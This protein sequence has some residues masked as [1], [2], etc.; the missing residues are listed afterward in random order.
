MNIF[1]SCCTRKKSPIYLLEDEE[2]EETG[3]K[4]WFS[5]CLRPKSTYEEGLIRLPVGRRT[6]DD[7]LDP[8]SPISIETLLADQEE[9]LDH[10]LTHSSLE[11]TF[12]RKYSL[13][14]TAI[15]E[16]EDAQFLSEHRISAILVD[17]PKLGG[18]NVF[19]SENI[20]PPQSQFIIPEVSTSSR[21]FAIKPELQD[22]LTDTEICHSP[23]E[24]KHPQRTT[25]LTIS[26]STSS[27]SNNNV[28]P[29]M[30][31]STSLSVFSAVNP[32]QD[33]TTEFP[34]TTLTRTPYHPIPTMH[35]DHIPI[36]PSSL[37][38]PIPSSTASMGRR[39]S[40]VAAAQ[41]L[42]GDKLDDFTEKLAFI[43]KNIIMSMDSEDEEELTENNHYYN[44]TSLNNN[45]KSLDVTQDTSERTWDTFVLPKFKKQETARPLNNNAVPP[46]V[47][48]RSMRRESVASFSNDSDDD[49]EPFDFSK[50]VAMSKN[51]RNFG[52]GVMGNG[53]RM[54][55]NL[56]TRIKN[57]ENK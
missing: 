11:G 56:S 32:T 51:V 15:M 12:K 4:T 8:R 24:L 53:L 3:L 52:E 27:E 45:R 50:V 21:I 9:E 29:T 6:I 26:S 48:Q 1:D 19:Q 35:Q 44:T 40:V 42:L 25:S 54:F 22:Q 55:N 28:N 30:G 41:S 23:Q 34:A 7:Y 33:R 57:H 14:N 38:T 5:C 49:E 20:S 18:A 36:P 17:R 2:E 16:E 47:T 31:S 46:D 13:V 39:P 10:Y 37:P 43:K